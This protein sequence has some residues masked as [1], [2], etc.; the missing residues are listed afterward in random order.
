MISQDLTGFI[1]DIFDDRGFLRKKDEKSAAGLPA[2]P[3]A[4]T[5]V[6]CYRPLGSCNR[7]IET[8]SLRLFGHVSMTI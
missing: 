5:S 4:E 6:S 7:P 2:W 3:C 8:P 1:I